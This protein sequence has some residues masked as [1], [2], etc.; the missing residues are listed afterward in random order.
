MPGRGFEIPLDVLHIGIM[1]LLP[2]GKAADDPDRVEADLRR[3]GKLLV[4]G[5]RRKI[6]NVFVQVGRQ[7]RCQL[8]PVG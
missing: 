5:A 6:H 8:L 3:H 7:V 1:L 4:R 2:H